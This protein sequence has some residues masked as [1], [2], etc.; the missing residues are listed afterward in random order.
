[1]PVIPP[2]HPLQ[3]RR[4][5]ANNKGHMLVLL[6]GLFRRSLARTIRR[7]SSAASEGCGR[8]PEAT[9]GWSR[10]SFGCNVY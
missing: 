6:S 1:M 3:D 7:R 8:S 9:F 2:Y 5:V 10:P 4:H